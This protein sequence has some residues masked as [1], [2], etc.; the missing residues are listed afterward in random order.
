M[1][2]FT[3]EVSLG[4][5]TEELNAFVKQGFKIEQIDLIQHTMSYIIIAVKK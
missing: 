2:Y 1:E 5:L 3:K 4:E